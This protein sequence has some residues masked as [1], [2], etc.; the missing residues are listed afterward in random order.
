MLT[1]CCK[2]GCGLGSRI[3][4]IMLVAVVWN[5]GASAMMPEQVTLD[6]RLADRDAASFAE[7]DD[8]KP[9]ASTSGE[10][11]S[12]AE[13]SSLST[14]SPICAA[15][16]RSA[17]ANDV[18]LNFFTR[19]IWQESRFNPRS[20][21][22]AGALGIAQF[23]PATARMRGLTDPFNPQQALLKSAE[24][25]RALIDR[26]GNP[27]LA[28]AAYNAGPGRV[29]EWLAGRRDLP[30]ETVAYVR[31]VTGHDASDWTAPEASTLI[32]DP[33][34]CERLANLADAELEHVRTVHGA[35]AVTQRRAT[36]RTR[37]P[38]SLAFVASR[39]E[40]RHVRQAHLVVRPGRG[41]KSRHA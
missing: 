40:H 38:A 26:F 27:G 37:F 35:Q 13:E 4:A 2:G 19:L 15:L 33:P 18:P 12:A 28:A 6:D 14:H 32:A 31:T 24:F 23:M 16:A 7:G 30:G 11:A 22:R 10:L 20:V 8:K 3:A 5:C 1:F 41:A 9:W 34:P 17:L 21:S 39:P 29:I 25:L 36:R